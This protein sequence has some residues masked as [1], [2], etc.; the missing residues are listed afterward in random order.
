MPVPGFFSVDSSTSRITKL[1]NNGFKNVNLHRNSPGMV[2]RRLGVG[3]VCR[4]SPD[5]C[6]QQTPAG[7]PRGGRC[8]PRRS[9]AVETE[10]RR[11]HGGSAMQRTV[12]FDVM[13]WWIVDVCAA[14]AAGLWDVRPGKRLTESASAITMCAFCLFK[15]ANAIA[16]RWCYSFHNSIKF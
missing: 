5:R 16:S 15:Q 9:R 7:I 12:R 8:L 1:Y 3:V 13:R 6:Q 14:V 10:Q 11:R 4:R 2:S